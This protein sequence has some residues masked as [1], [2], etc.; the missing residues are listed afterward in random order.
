M[1]RGERLLL[2]DHQQRFLQQLENGKERDD[3]AHAPLVE[4]E[5]VFEADEIFGIDPAENIARVARERGVETVADFFTET[6]ARR[7]ASDLVGKT[8]IL[9]PYVI[10]E[11][12]TVL[13]YKCGTDIAYSFL[14]DVAV[15]ERIIIPP[16]DIQT[17]IKMFI[18]LKRKISFTD[19]S[20]IAL[21]KQR[22]AQ[23]ITFDREILSLFK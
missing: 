2:H 23:I 10:Q 6:L 13:T 3:Q 20:L 1:N 15:A 12:A 16:P 4:I 8:I 21:A 22:G 7:I 19:A 14:A 5:Q 9:H 17:D 11:T 18:A